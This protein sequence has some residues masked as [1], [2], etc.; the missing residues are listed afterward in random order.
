MEI[1]FPEQISCHNVLE[2]TETEKL[3]QRIFFMSS[4]VV[5]EC[6]DE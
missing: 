5:I 6:L 1:F 2:T 3:Q 4:F